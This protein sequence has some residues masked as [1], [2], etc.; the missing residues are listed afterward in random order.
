MRR[1]KCLGT[2]ALCLVALL[3]AESVLAQQPQRVTETPATD[4]AVEI[5]Q[6]CPVPNEKV[7]FV[8]E[9][10]ML[11][12]PTTTTDWTTLKLPPDSRVAFPNHSLFH[13]RYDKDTRLLSVMTKVGTRSGNT[14][15][16]KVF[17]P[18]FVGSIVLVAS[19]KTRREIVVE[20]ITSEQEAER[21]ADATRHAEEAA[22]R[23][24]LE[25]RVKYLQNAIATLQKSLTKVTV[26]LA[27]TKRQRAS[28][29]DSATQSAMEASRLGDVVAAKNSELAAMRAELTRV[30]EQAKQEVIAAETKTREQAQ[31]DRLV[32]VA[33]EWL[34]ETAQ[35]LSPSI[36]YE[37]VETGRLAVRF[38]KAR[39]VDSYQLIA[40]RPSVASTSRPFR[41]ADAQVSTTSGQRLATQVVVPSSPEDPKEGVITTI[42]PTNPSPLVLAVKVP[43]DVCSKCL[44]LQLYEWGSI[45]PPVVAKIPPEWKDGRTLYPVPKE[46]VEE[47]ERRERWGQQVILGPSVSAGYCWLAES[48]G[49]P[50]LDSMPCYTLGLRLTKG[51]NEMFAFEAEA[52]GGW[53]PSGEMR[54]AKLGRAAL[55]GVLRFGAYTIPY[56]RLGVG[57][58]VASVDGSSEVGVLLSF[59]AG[60]DRR[61]SD[62]I[63][64]GV[65]LAVETNQEDDN[66]FRRSV[67]LGVHLSVGWNRNAQQPNE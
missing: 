62:N 13:H 43:P 49:S 5:V 32:D 58:Q 39:W 27:V 33:K 20:H 53:T 46:E 19:L 34:D 59:G 35:T 37:Y 38:L 42:H 3:R 51:F 6:G 61:L 44:V 56:A 57:A 16:L 25:D 21:K 24:E 10:N 30:K 28:A 12:I 8:G 55:A 60:V 40:F 23:Q 31:Q 11:C 66:A 14:A 54:S 41:L 63:L 4:A 1:W 48:A 26:E 47:R 9:G 22:K 50:T 52:L 36:E 17:G 2:S 18:E 7:F 29:L 45:K 15:S 65:G 64:V 67:G